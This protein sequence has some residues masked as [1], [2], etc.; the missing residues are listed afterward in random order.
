MTPP[1]RK[2]ACMKTSGRVRIV[3]QIWARSHVC[4]R[5]KRTDGN[6]FRVLRSTA[7]M[8]IA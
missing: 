4:T 2:A 8:K 7:K 3:S 6:F 1:K 5:P